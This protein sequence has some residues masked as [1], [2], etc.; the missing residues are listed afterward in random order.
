MNRNMMIAAVAVAAVVIAVA[1]AAIVLT[2]DGDKPSYSTETVA[3]TAYDMSSLIYAEKDPRSHD[4]AK[5]ISEYLVGDFDMVI[6][7]GQ[8][9]VLYATMDTVAKLLEKEFKDGASISVEESGE[10]HIMTFSSGGQAIAQ[11]SVDCS[12]RSICDAGSADVFIDHSP[13]TTV[14]EQM[15]CSMDMVVEGQQYIFSF[16]GYG[17][18]PIEDGGKTYFP[19]GLISLEL[20]RIDAPRAFICSTAD[21]MLFIYSQTGQLD[22]KF[23]NGSAGETSIA[24]IIGA[25]Y[26]QYRDAKGTINPP[27]YMLEHTRDLFYFMMDNYYGL[28]SVTGFESMSDYVRNNGYSDKLV[29]SDP[30]ERTVAYKVIV[31]YLQDCHTKYASSAVLGEDDDIDA[32]DYIQCLRSDRSVL[33]SVLQAQRGDFLAAEGVENIS[34]VRYSSDGR[35]AYF[36]FDNFEIATYYNGT[37]T[38]EER[39][40]DTYY[41]FVDRFSEIKAHGGVERVV[42]DDTCNGGGVVFIMGKLLALMSKDN[43]SRFAFANSNSGLVTEISCRV[44]S[45]GDG[46]YDERDVFGNDFDFYILTSSFSF[47]CGNSFPCL[48]KMNGI[49]TVI[50][51][52][53]GGGEMTVSNAIFPFGQSFGYSSLRHVSFYDHGTQTWKGIENGQPVDYEILSGWYDVDAISDVIDEFEAQASS[54]SNFK[55]RPETYRPTAGMK[56]FHVAFLPILSNLSLRPFGGSSM[57]I[58]AITRIIPM[59]S[60]I[61]NSSPNTTTPQMVETIRLDVIMMDTVAGST[62]RIP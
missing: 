62:R 1:A 54:R 20:Q 30:T 18:D 10:A 43:N 37:L 28:N 12:D 39:L 13:G 44:D 22:A 34:E 58:A 32:K 57:V 50:G 45:N 46:E 6:K 59:T 29:S 61:P 56:P 16:D 9:E 25:S 47:S 21:N 51:T 8:G 3:V 15:D 41:L 26:D 24:E 4:P 60:V 31:G 52:K 53:S 14:F 11:I 19:L 48:A 40:Q 23:V 2:S 17:L 27:A 49:A 38:P 42:I 7:K 5:D 55:S 33:R 35:T 36:S